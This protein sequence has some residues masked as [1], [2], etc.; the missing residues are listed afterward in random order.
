MRKANDYFFQ[1]DSFRLKFRIAIIAGV[2]R[3]GKTTLGNI[4]ATAKNVEHS[5]ESWLLNTLP[6]MVKLGMIDEKIGKELFLNYLSELVNDMILLRRANFRPG[7]LSSIWGQKSYKDIFLRLKTLESRKDVKSFLKAEKP[8]LLLNLSAS[9]M[10][11]LPLLSAWLSDAKIIHVTRRGQEVARDIERK[12]WF[13]NDQLIK[14]INAQIYKKVKHE[15]K[16]FYVPWWVSPKYGKRFLN[17][18]EYERCIFFWCSMIGYAKDTAERLSAKNKCI[19]IAFEDFV[20]SP[21][22]KLKQV[23]AFLNIK[24]TTLTRKVLRKFNNFKSTERDQKPPVLPK[25]LANQV[26]KTYQYLSYNEK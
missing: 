22:E 3:S 18:S 8:L 24:P 21:L 16:T 15:N 17:Y 19:T 12:K 2:N 14:P 26:K 4:F 23:S 25:N 11:A 5:D 13:S 20:A 6:I 9:A 10:F 7:D 1:P